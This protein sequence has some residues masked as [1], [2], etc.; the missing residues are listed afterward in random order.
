MNLPPPRWPT[1]LGGWAAAWGI[2]AWMS[3]LRYR[4]LLEDPRV[5]PKYHAPEPRI[6]VFWHEYILIPLYLR[7]HCDLTMLLSKHRDA[8]LLGVVAD[9]MGF[10]CV[11]GS[12]YNGAAA[13][14]RELTRRGRTQHLAITPD[15]PRGPRRTLAPGAVFLASRMQ[16]PIVPLGFGINRLWRAKSWDRFAIPQ[17]LAQVRCVIG[18]EIRVEPYLER[19]ALEIRR[20]QVEQKLNEVTQAAEQWAVEGGSLPGAIRGRREGRTSESPPPSPAAID[21]GWRAAS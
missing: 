7:G 14:L 2:R 21:A 1:R 3:G 13:A 11:R 15:G 8:D 18:Q 12:T 16:A 17:P 4:A 9:H 6:Y 19:A 10:E 20:Q 5:D